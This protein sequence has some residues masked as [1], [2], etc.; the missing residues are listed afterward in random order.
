MLLYIFPEVDFH[1]FSYFNSDLP[2]LKSLIGDI[3]NKVGKTINNSSE[4]CSFSADLGN[5]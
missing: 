4:I 5:M 3:V 1:L 2:T